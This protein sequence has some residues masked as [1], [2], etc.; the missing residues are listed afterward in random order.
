M[1]RWT[2]MRL[3]LPRPGARGAVAPEIA[4]TRCGRAIADRGAH[5][6][7]H[8]S[9]G[10]LTRREVR[11]ECTSLCGT[12]LRSWEAEHGDLFGVG[13]DLHLDEWQH[14]VDDGRRH[15][16]EPAPGGAPKEKRQ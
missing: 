13:S 2:E 3:H 7:E 5:T 16:K 11:Q 4:R 6:G 1:R 8:E 14:Q 12:C 15:L 10:D 9:E